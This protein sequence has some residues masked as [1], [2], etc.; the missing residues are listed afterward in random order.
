M[1]EVTPEATLIDWL[2]HHASVRPQA[3]ALELGDRF[4][5][6]GTLHDLVLRTAAGLSRHGV[7]KGD[8]VAIQLPNLVDYAVGFLAVTAIGGIVQTLHMPYRRAELT[9]LIAHSGA[10]AAICLE[11]F[12][13]R[14]VAAEFLAI[15]SEQPS[16]QIVITV[17]DPGAGVHRQGDVAF[18]ELGEA[19]P[20]DCTAGRQPDED[21]L[22]LYTSGTTA[23]PKGVPHTYRGF[24]G[25]AARSAVELEIGPQERL[26]S[27]AP[28]THLY[29]LFV[30]HLALAGGCT[31]CLLPAFNPATF[32]DDLLRTRATGIFAAPAHFAP[33]VAAGRL[34]ESH[35]AATRF[36][37]LSGA[38]VPPS[39]ARSV[40]TLMTEGGVI[41]LW[42]MSELQA[43]TYSRPGDPKDKRCTT[44]GR[45]SPNT[46]LR[47]VDEHGD[48]VPAGQEGELQVVGP[49]VF[50]G[51]LNNPAETS[52]SFSKDGWFRTGD[53]AVL[54]AD[55][56]LTLTGRLKE[57]IN[58]GGVKFNP[59]D[60]EIEILALEG[61]ANCAI[62]PYPCPVLG[63]R[64]CLCV[65]LY[66]DHSLTLE[67][68]TDRLEQAGFAKY[69]WPER[70]EILADLPMTPTRKVMRGKLAAMITDP[71][72][73]S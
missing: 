38:T 24:L 66:P 37:C 17:G 7:G 36:V 63:E 3:T 60:V 32:P 34:D 73:Q 50:S 62:V 22:L 13:D 14:N 54:D 39:L 57:I 59:V 29:G 5:S 27:A 21:F 25:N 33:F 70:L 51:Y 53:L 69:K 30:L 8:V 12:N 23:S 18:A 2:G 61:V 26:L 10:K 16:L 44:A 65:Q 56:Y 9:G 64:A 28:F 49:S 6:Y 72:D 11:R 55:G 35:L 19:A 48:A 68:V 71:Q 41:Q 20:T 47:I 45:A 31:L 67:T 52:A 40:D 46:R 43:G 42:G 4:V 58:R 15:K 1:I